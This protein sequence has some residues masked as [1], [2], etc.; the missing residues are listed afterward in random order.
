M[1][2]VTIYNWHIQLGPVGQTPTLRLPK[3]EQESTGML[4][5]NLIRKIG[6]AVNLLH[7]FAVLPAQRF[8]PV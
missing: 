5:Q 7:S 8:A 3:L 6:V 2:C 4:L 1:V